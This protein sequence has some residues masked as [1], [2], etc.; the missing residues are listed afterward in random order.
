MSNR[1]ESTQDER[2]PTVPP[3]PDSLLREEA[4]D[5]LRDR[6]GDLGLRIVDV[7][8]RAGISPQYLSEIERGLKDPSSEVLAAIAGALGLRVVDLL[9]EIVRRDRSRG[10]MAPRLTIHTT[11]VDERESSVRRPVLRAA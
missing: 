10:P 11:S 2:A 4:G 6:R 3:E 8:E 7:A 1:T 9:A 5:A